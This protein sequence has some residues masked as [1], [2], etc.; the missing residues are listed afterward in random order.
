M[1]TFFEVL[2]SFF[3]SGRYDRGGS[4]SGGPPRQWPPEALHRHS[5][6]FSQAFYA[7]VAAQCLMLIIFSLRF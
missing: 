3:L 5:N 4:G 2:R 7:D 1:E 6:F